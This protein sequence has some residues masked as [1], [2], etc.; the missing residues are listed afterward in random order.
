[1]GNAMGL[2]YT[3]AAKAAQRILTRREQ[4]DSKVERVELEEKMA[5]QGFI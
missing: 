1:V 5:L 4:K 3:Q 2:Y